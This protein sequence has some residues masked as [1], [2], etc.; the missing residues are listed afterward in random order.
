MIPNHVP[1]LDGHWEAHVRPVAD[2]TRALVQAA[3]AA[4]VEYLVLTSYAFLYGGRAAGDD[5]TEPD[6]GAS[7]IFQAALAAEE[8]VLGSSVPGCVLRAGFIYGARSPE[9]ITLRDSLVHGRS[10]ALGEASASVNWVQIDDLARAVVQ[11]IQARPAKVVL[12][13]VDDQPASAADVVAYL[14]QIMNLRP[15]GR[16]P[17]FL[18]SRRLGKTQAELL[19][20]TSRAS[21]ARA[22]EVLSWRP[23]FATFRQGIDDTLLTL[24]A[25]EP[26]G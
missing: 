19:A 11:A 18:V 17:G 1:M 6:P 20:R 21:S 15:P 4:G 25:E 5:T 3:E 26:V 13:I 14:A 23:R 7:P 16:A 9:T 12:N 10:L 22:A 2:G 24:R 8:A